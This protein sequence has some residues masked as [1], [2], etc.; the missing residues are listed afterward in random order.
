MILNM[1]CVRAVLL[2]VEQ[3]QHF[4]IDQ[5]GAVRSNSLQIEDIYDLVPSYSKEDICYSVFN[6]KQAGYIEVDKTSAWGGVILDVEVKYLTFSGH[7]FLSKIR[8][9][10]RW[11]G[12]KKALPAIR[13]YSLDAINAISQG[14]TSAAISAF[15]AKN[16]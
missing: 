4:T 9:T 16:P 2:A 15:L 8:D 14:M 10:E 11:R 13:N 1:D 7:E 6:M 5:S 12:I 3:H